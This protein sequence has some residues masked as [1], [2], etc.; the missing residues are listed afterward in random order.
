VRVDRTSERWRRLR[1]AIGG[2]HAVAADEHVDHVWLTL[3]AIDERRERRDR[4]RAA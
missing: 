3:A 4:R 1:A 2:G